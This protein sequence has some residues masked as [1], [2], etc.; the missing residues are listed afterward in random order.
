[1]NVCTDGEAVEQ[2]SVLEGVW[3]GCRRCE[4]C[5]DGRRCG[6][7]REEGVRLYANRNHALNPIGTRRCV[8]T[9]AR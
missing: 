5:E 2:R 4:R 7:R 6:G 1:V 9:Y 3:R 8:W